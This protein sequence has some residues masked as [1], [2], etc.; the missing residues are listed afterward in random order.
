M[1]WPHSMLFHIL[2]SQYTCCWIHQ[3]SKLLFC[4]SYI[5]ATNIGEILDVKR[6]DTR[7][8]FMSTDRCITI[9][10]IFRHGWSCRQW[11]CNVI[12][13]L[14]P[15]LRQTT[16]FSRRFRSIVWHTVA[17]VCW[18]NIS[19]HKQLIFCS[20]QCTVCLSSSSNDSN[21]SVNHLHDCST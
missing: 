7:A 10:T 8:V 15:C 6:T 14:I 20:T 9:F 19:I 3:I 21:I 11:T 13:Q 4:M 17:A 2:W 18:C 16:S 1:E 5:F 12:L